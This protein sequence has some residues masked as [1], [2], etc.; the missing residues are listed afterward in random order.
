MRRVL[1]V[2][3]SLGVFF[4]FGSAIA[5]ASHYARYG[6]EGRGCHSW[7]SKYDRGDRFDR[8]GRY[9]RNR[10]EA[11]APAA[12]PAAPPVAA[13]QTIVLQA[14]AAPAPVYIVVPQGAAPAGQTIVLQPQ[15]APAPVPAVAPSS[16]NT[17]A[18]GQ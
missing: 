2:V 18:V 13:P 4:G 17:A 16:V 9:D 11:P 6:G 10:N 7:Q 14:P 8:H 12:A 3:L 15:A 1:I 5:R